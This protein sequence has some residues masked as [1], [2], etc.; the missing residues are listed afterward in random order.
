MSSLFIVC[1]LALLA[2]LSGFLVNQIPG[3]Q[4]FPGRNI[5]IFRVLGE[6]VALSIILTAQNDEKLSQ[7]YAWLATGVWVIGTI[8]FLDCLQMGWAVWRHRHRTATEPAKDDMQLRA[9]LL[10]VLSQDIRQRQQ[11]NFK[12]LEPQLVMPLKMQDMPER[13]GQPS[14][15]PSQ[16]AKMPDDS[17]KQ[18]W[19]PIKR[20]LRLNDRPA[21]EIPNTRRLIDV[22]RQADRR[23]LVLGKP[24]AGKTT[25]LLELA[26][27]LL[28]DA[29]QPEQTQITVR[30]ECSTWKDDRQPLADWLILQLKDKYNVP[31]GVSRSWIEGQKLVPLLDGLDELGLTRQKAATLAIAE[32]MRTYRYPTI[33]VISF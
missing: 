31:S 9:E 29:Q 28:Q 25:L 8:L 4:S 21:V 30:L 19:I 2:L 6:V 10:T 18:A 1:G 7:K 32:F 20:F 22:F 11:E 12:N 13:V 5:F 17:W 23:L 15:I 14:L 26:E 3:F 16:T 27:Q 33:R 24:G